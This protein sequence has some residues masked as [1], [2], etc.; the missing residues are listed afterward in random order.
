MKPI[1]TPKTRRSGRAAVAVGRV[2]RVRLS[3]IGIHGGGIVVIL[4][5][6]ATEP[7]ATTVAYNKMIKMTK[8]AGKDN[9]TTLHGTDAPHTSK[10]LTGR[11]RLFQGGG[12]FICTV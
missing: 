11:V 9:K 4:G 3:L 6:Y 7:T 2:R 8:D 1:M 12:S 5:D 10:P